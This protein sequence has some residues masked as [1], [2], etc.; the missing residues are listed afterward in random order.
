M[1]SETQKP[2]GIKEIATALGISI[3]TVDR[4]LHGRPGISEKTRSRVLKLAASMHYQPNL[5]ARQLKLNRQIRVGV[6]LPLQISS[7]FEPL[8]Q[9]IRAA[10]TA[11]HGI[12]VELNFHDYPRLGSSDVKVMEEDKRVH[13]DAVILS[14]GNPKK[15]GP[16]LR[17][18]AEAETA[19][20][21][22]ATDAPLS[23]RIASIAVDAEVSGGLAAELLGRTLFKPA[24][25]AVITGDLET[26]DHVHKL[27]G[28]AATCATL[29]PHLSLLPIIETHDQPREA[30]QATLKLLRRRTRPEG[31]Y[32]STANGLPVLEAIREMKLQGKVQVIATDLYP[33]LLPFLESGEVL[34][35]LHQRPFTQGKTAFEALASFILR[36]E[37]PQTLTRLAPHIVMRSN[38]SIFA[39]ELRENDDESY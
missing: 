36:G 29:S 14:P 5:A 20:I 19:V 9:G 31:L 35:S 1:S 2:T 6:Y 26:E 37:R 23:E 8:R 38:L 33:E 27:R 4:A 30:Y 25:V 3:G 22:V 7:F 32:V 17:R 12:Q 28:F 34:A 13:H 15:I 18:L 10:A 21:C 16:V 11:M 39:K 24:S